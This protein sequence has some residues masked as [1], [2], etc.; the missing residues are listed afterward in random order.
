MKYTV[1]AV[2][3]VLVACATQKKT[4]DKV[5]TE[6]AKES[7]IHDPDTFEKG[8]NE[9]IDS[10]TSL[11][12]EQKKG[13]HKILNETRDQNRKLYEQSL[14][15]RVVLLKE[16]LKKDSDT[17]EVKL[18]KK[19]IQNLE[20]DRLKNTFQTVD[21]ISHIVKHDEND[22]DILNQVIYLDRFNH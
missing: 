11:D 22:H 18:L 17:K 1:V 8:I 6:V 14:K 7:R 5:K 21:Q 13:L 2:M 19:Q 12:A 9:A 10:S 16:L 20:N 15:L 4:E 3:F